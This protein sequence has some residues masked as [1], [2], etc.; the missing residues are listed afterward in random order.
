VVFLFCRVDKDKITTDELHGESK[1]VE[2]KDDKTEQPSE[3]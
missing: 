1:S 3:G 2:R